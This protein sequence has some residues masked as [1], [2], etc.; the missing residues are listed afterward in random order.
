LVFFESVKLSPRDLIPFEP[1]SFDEIGFH[2]VDEGAGDPRWE[3][4][5]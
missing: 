3:I 2:I 5:G 4:D 1:I